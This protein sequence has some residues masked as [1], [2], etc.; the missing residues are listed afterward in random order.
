[1]LTIKHMLFIFILYATFIMPCC[2]RN[3]P[4]I[5]DE[6]YDSFICFEDTSSWFAQWGSSFGDLASDV[7]IGPDG[8]IY[9]IGTINGITDLDPGKNILEI[10]P[11]DTS[12]TYLSKFSPNG[13]FICAYTWSIIDGFCCANDLLIDNIG[14]IYIVGT[15]I[16]SVDLD[17]GENQD[18]IHSLGKREFSFLVKLNSLGDYEYSHVW[19]GI[20]I[21]NAQCASNGDI[22]LSGSFPMEYN[23]WRMPVKLA[24][25]NE[26]DDFWSSGKTDGF[27]SVYNSSGDI[28]YSITFGGESHD[29]CHGIALDSNDNIYILT[30]FYDS[31][32]IDPG[33]VDAIRA[34][35]GG[36][37]VALSK[38]S[39]EGE[40]Q[41]YKVWGAFTTSHITID[42]SDNLL[43]SGSFN[44]EVDLDPGSNTVVIKPVKYK[45][46]FYISQFDNDGNINWVNIFEGEGFLE[47][48][49]TNKI[50][51]TCFVG[52]FKNLIRMNGSVSEEILLSSNKYDIFI[53]NLNDSGE[54][55]WNY[56][57]GGPGEERGFG[58]TIDDNGAIFTVGRFEDRIEVSNG[59]NTKILKSN[60][61]T[62]AI[63]FKIH[64]NDEILK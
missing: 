50:G 45:K 31:I 63:L 7:A 26:G 40:F 41:W 32:N 27:V 10:V 56:S 52:S 35:G 2:T 3:Q 22:I 44:N 6:I 19:R 18:I 58:I 12:A 37:S 46:C 49:D 8:N 33:P 51:E 23:E 38:F 5:N 29:Y 39:I 43:V 14:N 55:Q 28:K 4:S 11:L 53:A 48:I 47:H 64:T 42:G 59:E 30:Q 57:L 24:P 1:M 25:G 54:I 62:D 9:V 61:N 13:D 60:G 36:A 20:R 16:G 21:S 17:P 34:K 15:F